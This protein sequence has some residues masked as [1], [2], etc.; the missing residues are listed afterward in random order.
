MRYFTTIRIELMAQSDK[1]ALE[2]SKIINRS[3]YRF[4]DVNSC[5]V[6]HVTKQDG[7]DVTDLLK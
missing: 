6:I 5:D 4:D 3:L 2:E 1:E 7:L